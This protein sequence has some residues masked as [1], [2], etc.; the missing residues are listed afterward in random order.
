MAIGDI[1]TSME[2][3]EFFLQNNDRAMILCKTHSCSVC[4]SIEARFEK[5][6]DLY[7]RWPIAYVYVDDL[8][9]FRGTH[10]V[11]TV[12]TVLMFFEQKE[13]Y[14]TSRFIEFD[15]IAYFIDAVG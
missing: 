5:D 12:P 13:I 9:L 11:F 14:R 10:S 3:V 1:L 7:E 4:L 15:R 8:E 2:E 6:Q